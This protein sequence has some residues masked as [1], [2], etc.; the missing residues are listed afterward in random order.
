MS[1][2]NKLHNKDFRIKVRTGLDADLD[3]FK[4]TA[5]Q[6]ELA[7]TTDTCRLFATETTAASADSTLT[8]IQTLVAPTYL[9]TTATYTIDG[10]DRWLIYSGSGGATIILPSTVDN[11]PGRVVTIKNTTIHSITLSAQGSDLI[12][13][14][15]TAGAVS[16]KTIGNGGVES[17]VA[18]LSGDWNVVQSA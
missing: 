16:D 4:K 1:N 15:G 3:K 2:L 8:E 18:G 9:T 14:V 10:R 7:F 12:Y 13:P 17:L 6:G 11:S 5:V